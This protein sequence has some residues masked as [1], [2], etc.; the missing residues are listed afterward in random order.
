M[1]ALTVIAAL[2]YPNRPRDRELWASQT[3]E[4]EIDLWKK[5][6]F[7]YLYIHCPSFFPHLVMWYSCKSIPLLNFCFSSCQIISFYLTSPVKI[8]E[9]I[10]SVMTCHCFLVSSD[11]MHQLHACKACAIE[12]TWASSHTYKQRKQTQPEMPWTSLALL[13]GAAKQ[14]TSSAHKH[15]P[16]TPFTPGL[17]KV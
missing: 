2:P 6:V 13:S 8:H 5:S 12:I 10:L 7:I 16:F 14:K 15:G 4:V 9:L 11:R 3:V 17:P 1:K